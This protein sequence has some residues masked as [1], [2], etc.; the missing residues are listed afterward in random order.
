MRAVYRPG[1]E[2]GHSV[3]A[4]RPQTFERAVYRPGE[5]LGHSVVALRPQTFERAVYRPGAQALTPNG[6]TGVA[7]RKVCRP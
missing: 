2:L 4:L 1:E 3:V 5:E 7:M 6:A